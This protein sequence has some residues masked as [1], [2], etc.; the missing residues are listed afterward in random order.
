MVQ[1]LFLPTNFLKDVGDG[2]LFAGQM[3]RVYVLQNEAGRFYIGLS[4]DVD[5]RLEQHHQGVSKWTKTRGP[6]RLVWQSEDLSLSDARK[7]ENHL[8]RQKGRSRFLRSDWPREAFPW[9]IIPLCGSEVQILS[10]QP[11]SR[12]S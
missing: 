12:G 5:R 1:I 10:P 4:D 8:K 3:Y 11:F 7:L 9:L 6:W 2:V